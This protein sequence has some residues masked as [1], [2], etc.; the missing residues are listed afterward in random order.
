MDFGQR[1]GRPE[2]RLFS[3]VRLG[4]LPQS[5]FDSSNY[6]VDVVFT[7][8]SVDTTPPT[9]SAV[10]A[11]PGATTATITWT[12][13]EAST[14]R[15]HYGTS[16]STLTPTA[17]DSALVTG[18]SVSLI[19]LSPGIT[20]FFRVASADAASNSSTSPSSPATFTTLTVDTTP[21]TISPITAAPSSTS[22][23]IS[24]TTNE[25]STTRVDYGTSPSAL[26]QTASNATL[27]ASH[28]IS[29][30][31]L[32]PNTTY[33][34]RVTSVDAATNSSTS[35]ADPNNPAS[36]TTL[37]PATTVTSTIFGNA[38][39]T[40]I[41]DGDTAS[42]EL[43]MKFRSDVAGTVTGVR[44]YKAASNTG[45]HTGSLWSSTGTLLANVTFSNETASGWQQAS[46]GRAVQLLTPGRLTLCPITLRTD[47]T[48]A[49]PDTSR[50]PG[51]IIHL[52]MPCATAWMGRAESDLYGAGGFPNQTFSSSN[53]YVDVVFSTPATNSIRLFPASTVIQTGTL[54]AGTAAGLAA[55]DNTFYQVRST[56][57]KDAHH[58][59]VRQLL[60]R[61]QHADKS[62]CLLCWQ[63]LRNV[64][65][66]AIG[67]EFHHQRLG[68]DELRLRGNERDF[69]IQPGSDGHPC[70]LC[71]RD[72]WHRGSPGESELFGH[73]H[74]HR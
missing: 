49:I 58:G 12:T 21:P 29:L 34:F 17:T 42:V 43:G 16:A 55:D 6:W 15:V 68:A 60:R 11:N 50:I 33:S 13:N 54:N 53:Y 72:L 32:T 19:N 28:S 31:S 35:P 66:G 48:P 2:W 41:D 74:L 8:S 27:V 3:M 51:S 25:A 18:H 39:P 37:P 52:S 38:V 14:S 71:Q 65:R 5:R 57:I 24:W 23:T 30:T 10:T 73:S 20:Y 47:T 4:R 40:T 64:Y 69:A 26:N 56:N 67:L 9:I 61:T 1:R 7:T 59:L 44:F 70:R 46:F 22:A 36:F 62:C 63:E 45:V